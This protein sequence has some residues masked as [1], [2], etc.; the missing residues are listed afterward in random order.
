MEL[1]SL[2]NDS[3]HN[4]KR[5]LPLRYP[6]LIVFVLLMT[7]SLGVLTAEAD[8][9]APTFTLDKAIHFTAPDGSDLEVAPGLYRVMQAGESHMRITGEGSPPV[10][11]QAAQIAHEESLAAPAVMIV[12]EEEQP[13]QIHLVL[14]L[15]GGQ[16]LDAI[17]SFSGTRARGTPTAP[18]NAWQIKAVTAQAKAPIAQSKVLPQVTTTPQTFRQALPQPPGTAAPQSGAKSVAGTWITWSY[19]HQKHP[20]TV[21]QSLADVQAGK[22]PRT[23]LS[24]LASQAELTEMLKTN[25]S[26]E[27]KKIHAA[28]IASQPQ[29][30][31]TSRD[32]PNS[33]REKAL[34]NVINPPID[35]SSVL[36]HFTSNVTLPPQDIGKVYSG[37]LHTTT[38]ILNASEDGH[39]QAEFDLAETKK[40]FRI[41]ELLTY[42]GEFVFITG[43]RIAKIDQHVYGGKYDDIR[44]KPAPDSTKVSMAGFGS[45][46]VKRGQEVYVIVGFEPDAVVGPPAGNYEVGLQITTFNMNGS[47]LW[48]RTVP[49]RARCEGINF[50]VIFYAEQGDAVTLTNQTVEYPVV[51]TNASANPMAATISAA[52]LPAG[53]TMAPLSITLKGRE[54]QR[55]VLRFNVADAA[56]DGRAQPIVVNVA[57]GGQN[58]PVNLN[59]TIYHPWVWWEYGLGRIPGVAL[60]K[61]CDGIQ[62]VQVWIREDGLWWW[63]VEAYNLNDIDIGGSDFDVAIHFNANSLVNDRIHAHIGPKTFSQYYEQTHL[64][65][66]IHTNFLEA[67][68]TGVSF[69]LDP[70]N[71]AN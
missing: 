58:R 61:C 42:T 35:Y 63:R 71:A 49:I 45:I 36:K 51:A 3:S 31:V 68:D 2:A 4:K 69:N 12:P 20:E 70:P 33:V 46:N 11:M 13:D 25:W 34:L 19:L 44:T 40:R 14:L 24:G 7:A 59:L 50:G 18:L 60:R 41:V 5:R 6:V 23:F 53:V 27:V 54:T 39:L 47:R 38:V 62:S 29:A 26:D 56:E 64:H 30:G 43:H 21:M 55:Q 37:E 1:F 16:G 67:A 10:D 8:E 15:P 32:I 57:A 66:W 28:R 9:S 48:G 17:G 22:R 65:P 52:K